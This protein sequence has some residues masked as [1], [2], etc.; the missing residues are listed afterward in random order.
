MDIKANKE[1][2]YSLKEYNKQLNNNY[3]NVI[4]DAA[5]IEKKVYPYTIFRTIRDVSNKNYNSCFGKISEKGYKIDI[6]AQNKGTKHTKETIA[7]NIAEQLDEFM[8]FIGLNRVSYNSIDFE[9]EG[10]TLHLILTYSGNLDEYRR[11]FI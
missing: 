3:G 9:N 4:L 1:L 7:E 10:T 8:S 11:K 5:P 2:Y 6:Y